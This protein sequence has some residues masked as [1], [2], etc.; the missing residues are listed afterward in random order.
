VDTHNVRRRGRHGC[1]IQGC[2]AGGRENLR[3]RGW[4]QGRRHVIDT[5]IGRSQQCVDQQWQTMTAL[6]GM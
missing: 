4:L 2:R 1:G 6:R 5:I 3:S